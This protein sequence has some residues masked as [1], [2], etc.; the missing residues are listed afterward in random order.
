MVTEWQA[1]FVIYK[2]FQ[3]EFAK[4]VGYNIGTELTWGL[5]QNLWKGT[6]TGLTCNVLWKGVAKKC[7]GL[8]TNSKWLY[9]PS[10]KG[11]ARGLCAN[12]SEKSLSGGLS[13]KP[14]KRGLCE[15]CRQTPPENATKMVTFR[16]R[17]FEFCWNNRNAAECSVSSTSDL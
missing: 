10:E 16:K 14:S 15:C 8:C 13:T 12:L 17:E 4:P 6:W 2:A 9:E 3:F 1:T 11:L 5:L 7:M